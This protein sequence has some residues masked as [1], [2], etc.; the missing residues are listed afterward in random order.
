MGSCVGSRTVNIKINQSHMK[1]CSRPIKK[2]EKKEKKNIRI[3][4]EAILARSSWM[5]ILDYMKFTEL[6]EI[7]KVNRFFNSMTKSSDI[8]LKFFQKKKD[9]SSYYNESTSN[10]SSF[11]P[12]N[13][14]CSFSDNIKQ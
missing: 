11:L 13:S 12:N 3:K 1:T 8:L 5:N 9:Y 10:F 4:K 7:G 6:K 14:F 2:E